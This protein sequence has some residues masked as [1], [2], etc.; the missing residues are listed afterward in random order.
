LSNFPFKKSDLSVMGRDKLVRLCKYFR[1]DVKKGWSDE[2]IVNELWR[3]FHPPVIIGNGTFTVYT[4][5][6][7][8]DNNGDEIITFNEQ[9]Y[10][11]SKMSARHLLMLRMKK[12]N[13]ND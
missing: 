12:E 3:K 7:E 1:V 2:K 9:V 5:D 13:E 4:V 8:V 6:R 10:N 11:L